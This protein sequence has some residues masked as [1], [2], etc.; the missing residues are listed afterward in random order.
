MRH[1]GAPFATPAGEGGGLPANFRIEVR[2]R[3]GA[4]SFSMDDSVP[5]EG[6]KDILLSAPGDAVYQGSVVVDAPIRDGLSLAPFLTWNLDVSEA[7]EP[8]RIG[9]F[10]SGP[11]DA[12]QLHYFPAEAN[13]TTGLGIAVQNIGE[14]EITC[15]LDFIDEDG[16]AAG[17]ETIELNPLG[18]FVGFFN[19][20]VP[21]GF[22]GGGNFTCD[23]PVLAV[24][25]TQDFANGG[26]PTDR[27]TIKGVN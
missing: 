13:E 15:I 23:A 6:T 1:I 25:V 14:N 22:K 18:S 8:L 20:S 2:D 5:F 3:E 26:F 27:L 24:A 12:A 9:A 10:F 21:V 16:N 19:S 17:Q 7:L 4:I 11:Q